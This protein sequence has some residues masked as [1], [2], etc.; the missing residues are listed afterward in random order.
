MNIN[1]PEI[2]KTLWRTLKARHPQHEIDEQ[3]FQDWADYLNEPI[4]FEKCIDCHETIFAD[5]D[6]AMLCVKCGGRNRLL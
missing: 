3:S 1:P 6:D 5:D 2:L 4:R